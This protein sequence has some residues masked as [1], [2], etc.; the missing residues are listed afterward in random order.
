[1]VHGFAKLVGQGGVRD[2][3]DRLLRKVA[4]KLN[5][6]LTEWAHLLAVDVDGADKLIVLEHRHEDEGAGTASIGQRNERRD[7]LDIGLLCPDVGDVNRLPRA[8]KAE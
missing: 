1:M 7:A 2:G 6:L 5:L 3:E 8:S 4:D